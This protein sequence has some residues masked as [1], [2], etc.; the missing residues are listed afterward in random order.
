MFDY[1][2]ELEDTIYYNEVLGF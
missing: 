2:T 1:G